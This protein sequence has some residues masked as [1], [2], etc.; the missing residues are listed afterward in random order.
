M[1]TVITCHACH[2]TVNLDTGETTR[3]AEVAT[4]YAAHSGHPEGL[5]IGLVL[6]VAPTVGRVVGPS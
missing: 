5:G 4:F 2:A 6:R 3:V 1:D